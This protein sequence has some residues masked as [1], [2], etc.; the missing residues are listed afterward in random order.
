MTALPTTRLD[1]SAGDWPTLEDWIGARVIEIGVT[2][3]K[4][5]LCLT[6]QL[7]I[8]ESCGRLEIPAPWVFNSCLTTID[9]ETSGDVKADDFIGLE[10][11]Q[12]TA[13]ESSSRGMDC[14]FGS[15]TISV[16]LSDLS[17]RDDVELLVNHFYESVQADAVLGP[18][19][20]EVAQIDWSSHLPRMVDFWDTVMFRSGAYRGNPLSAHAKLL[21]HVEMSQALFDR[22]LT[23][24]RRAVHHLF[25][26]ENAGHIVR[27]AEDMAN[28]IH[29]KLAHLPR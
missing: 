25:A 29:D 21:P 16:R 13:V 15:I 19:F 14:Q 22:W 5:D 17:C 27:C 24:F 4:S 28:V 1:R 3:P 23:L 10:G 6:L 8:S 7:S 20:N 9:V 18:V 11:A 26:G 12:L 2:D